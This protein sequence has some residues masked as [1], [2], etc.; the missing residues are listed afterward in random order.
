MPTLPNMPDRP[1]PR[2]YPSE[3]LPA[4]KP[5]TE[6]TTDDACGRISPTP[7]TKYGRTGP[8][9]APMSRLLMTE[10]TELSMPGVSPK[11]FLA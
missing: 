2:S 11:K 4:P 7:M 9:P 3:F 10:K 5:V 8:T 1:P 6:P